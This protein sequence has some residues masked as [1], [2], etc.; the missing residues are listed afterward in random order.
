M[1][2]NYFGQL[3]DSYPEKAEML[4]WMKY[5]L[6]NRVYYFGKHYKAPYEDRP[7]KVRA[8]SKMASLYHRMK[9]ISIPYDGTI[10]SNAYFNVSDYIRKEG[11][12]VAL[13]PWQ[14]GNISKC[15][16]EIFDQM[17]FAEF[18]QVL[19]DS[20]K[21]KVYKLKEEL[22]AFF[23]KNH[24]P[25]LLLAND[26]VPIH[27]IAIDVCKELGIPTGIFLHGLPGRYDA[28]DDSRCDYL[29]VWGERIKDNYINAGS[30]TNII[31]T[32]H[33]NFSSFTLGDKIAENVL[34]ISRAIN[35]APPYS[36]RHVVDE[37]GIC[38]QHI[39]AIETAL[40]K[41]GINNAILRLHPSENPEWYSKFMDTNFYTID[42]NSLGYSIS[43]AKM[44]VGYCSTVM[45]DTVLN[46]VPYYSYVFDK[47]SNRYADEI[48]P[49]FCNKAE[50]PNA[51]TVDEL[52]NNINN[53]NF[54]TKEHFNGYIDPVFDIKKITQLFNH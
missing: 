38:V 13:P 11:F 19:T 51:Y 54:V 49:P 35:G 3:Q 27:R 1:L 44:V 36:D 30:K 32:G 4:E 22:T 33:P 9:T 20:F 14:T 45:L 39:Y 34:V 53:E 37:R 29:F 47:D 10:I 21:E 2:K 16:Q 25:F 8:F 42:T 40:K 6:D 50:F 23:Q 5:A 43:H 41:V 52:I 12:R 46:G 15:S 17:M 28:L 7:L 48:V 26:L 24:T 18:N 31:V